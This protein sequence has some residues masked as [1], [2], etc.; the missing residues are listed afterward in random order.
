VI[1]GDRYT[2]S[3]KCL[4]ASNEPHAVIVLEDLTTSG[5]QMF[6]RHIGFDLEHCFRVVEKLAQMHAASVIMYDKDPSLVK[7]YGEGL[8][9]DNAMIREWV[10]T[11]VII[12]AR[13]INHCF[14]VSA[15]YSALSDACSRWPGFE[16]YGYK[17][18]ALGDEALERGFRATRRKLGGFHVLNHGDLWVNNMMFSYDTNNTLKDMRFVCLKI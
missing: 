9:A 4:L 1:L 17:L 15:G 16:K 11:I 18:T 10:I 3:S 2:L 13:S 14:K 6:P 12:I 7:R 5:F 8:Y